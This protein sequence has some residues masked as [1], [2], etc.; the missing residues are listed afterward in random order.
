M[1][2]EIDFSKSAKLSPK[3]ESWDKVLQ[4]ISERSEQRENAR[5]RR[6]SALSAAA[7]VILVTGA[8]LIG[9]RAESASSAANI[10]DTASFESLSWYASLGDGK[11]VSTFTTS[12][13]NYYATRE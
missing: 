7:S 4:R 11:A 2:N 1:P 5:L 10:A 8:L 3:A 13:E 9:Y 12:L 6:F